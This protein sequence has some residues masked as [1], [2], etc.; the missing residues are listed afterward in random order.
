MHAPV[1][2]RRDELA[3]GVPAP[4]AGTP[5]AVRA[6]SDNIEESVMSS[7][8]PRLAAAVAAAAF[9][10]ACSG[11]PQMPP[12]QLATAAK[13]IES[14]HVAGAD[15]AAQPDMIKARAKLESARMASRSGDDDTARQLAEEAEV[16][17]QAARAKA[18]HV[19][20]TRILDSMEADLRSL[21]SLPPVTP[22][23]AP[24]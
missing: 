12:P 7:P 9:L 19:R 20:S 10:A 14:A 18:A 22:A 11:A 23:A 2:I 6:A 16:E 8:P 5:S 13:A 4:A 3:P 24:R 21:Q 1:P 17:A 15:E